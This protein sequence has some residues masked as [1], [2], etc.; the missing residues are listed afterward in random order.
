MSSPAV[1]S[2]SPGN[3]AG[4]RF[5]RVTAILAAA[6]FLATGCAHYQLGTGAELKYA[7]IYVEPVRSEALIPQSTA[8]VGT[9]VR[10]AFIRDGRIRLAASAAEAD[11]VLQIVLAKYEREIATVRPDDT[12]LARRYDITMTAKATL[13][14]NRAGKVLFADRNL[15]ARRGV[16]TDGGQIPAEYQN[17]P[18]LAEDIARR[19]VGAVLDTW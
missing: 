7:S 2:R 4:R 6:M 12:G 16:F 10:E 11:L 18:V 9:Q 1:L 15:A 5:G 19:A 3:E 8:L 14:D 13:T 17:L